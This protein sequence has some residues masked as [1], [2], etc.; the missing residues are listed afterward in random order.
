MTSVFSV[1]DAERH[2]FTLKKLSLSAQEW[3]GHVFEE[4]HFEEHNLAG[5]INSYF[6][7][8][9]RQVYTLDASTTIDSEDHLLILIREL[10][11]EFMQAG[12][13]RTMKLL[14]S[15]WYFRINHTTRTLQNTTLAKGMV[16][17]RTVAGT[18]YKTIPWTWK[19]ANI[20][21]TVW[22][23]QRYPHRIL[24][25]QDNQGNSGELLKTLR[26]PYWNQQ[27]NTDQTKRQL[28]RIP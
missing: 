16:T 7:Q 2:P 8:E 21:K 10:K 20:E 27:H 3:C 24:A 22:V 12:E 11:G 14:P 18:E 25:W 1:I 13:Q 19:Y 15:L 6:A 28:L 26:E 4:V 9:G 17:A 23:E 5:K